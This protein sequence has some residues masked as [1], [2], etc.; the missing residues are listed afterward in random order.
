MGDKLNGKAALLAGAVSVIALG[1]SFILKYD[2][3]LLC[4]LEADHPNIMVGGLDEQKLKSPA[5]IRKLFACGLTGPGGDNVSEMV[6]GQI[7]TAVGLQAVIM[8]I[9]QAILASFGFN[10]D[11]TPILKAED[12]DLKN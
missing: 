9:G 2:F 7:I 1:A 6:A 11:G 3:N 12:D 10:L 4:D 8:L 5:Y